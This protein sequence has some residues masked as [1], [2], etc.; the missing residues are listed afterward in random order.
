MALHLEIEKEDAQ[1]A[2][3]V[4]EALKEF[5]PEERQH[6]AQR[7]FS[8]TIAGVGVGGLAVNPNYQPT[9][10]MVA[11]ERRLA[12]EAEQRRREQVQREH[13]LALARASAPVININVRL[14]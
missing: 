3:E 14:R 12:E 6:A 8:Q 9:P 2:S 1:I 10:T 11:R 13:E 4:S 7:M 5:P